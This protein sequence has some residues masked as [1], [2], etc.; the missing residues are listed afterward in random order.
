MFYRVHQ[1]LP[2][3]GI[4]CTIN[5]H[6]CLNLGP[7]PYVSPHPFASSRAKSGMILQLPHQH[8]RLQLRPP[9]NTKNIVATSLQPSFHT[10]LNSRQSRIPFH[11]WPG[12]W[13]PHQLER[14]PLLE[15]NKCRIIRWFG[16]PE[17]ATSF[18]TIASRQDTPWLVVQR[19]S[20][21]V[22]RS[23]SHWQKD[24]R[25]PPSSLKTWSC[26]RQTKN[27][28]AAPE[29]LWF[30][31]KVPGLLWGVRMQLNLQQVMFG[32]MAKR[33]PRIY[34]LTEHKIWISFNQSISLQIIAPHMRPKPRKK[35]WHIDEYWNYCNNFA[36]KEFETAC[37]SINRVR[38]TLPLVLHTHQG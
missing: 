3:L 24:Y 20:L 9:L 15:N 30:G 37:R 22:W 17:N 29:K 21:E 16:Q 35:Y 1:G 4:F 10:S 31:K 12:T 25:L 33:P 13:A 26:V 27:F 14:K 8:Y 38:R 5:S 32:T 18:K 7:T 34:L 28:A 19:N 23:R 36:H 11:F 2:I 6:F